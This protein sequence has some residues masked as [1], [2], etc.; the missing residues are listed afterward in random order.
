MTASHEFTRNFDELKNIVD[1]THSF[2]EKEGIDPSLRHIVDLC[3]EELFVNMV[4]YNTETTSNIK[5]EMSP[6]EHGVEVSLTDY[7]VDR[8]DPRSARPVDIDAPLE[9][10][11]VGGL[12]LYLV[13][14]MA[15]AI[16]Y[17]YR[18]RTSKITFIADRK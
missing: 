14:K 17:E 5:L 9:N 6:H 1:F 11:S 16:H 8:F 12:G 2:F 7:D 13:L 10:R 4:N 18:N 15:D 3:V